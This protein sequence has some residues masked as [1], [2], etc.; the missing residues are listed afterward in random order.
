MDTKKIEK[1]LKTFG[2]PILMVISG[3]ILLVNPDGATALVTKLVGWVLVI[4]GA[5]KLVVPAVDKR[6]I[7]PGDWMINGIMILIGVILLAKPLILA[8]LIGRLLGVVLLAEGIRNL[9]ISGFG[10]V[11]ALTIVAGAVLIIMPRTLTNTV[12]AICGIVLMVIGVV[13]ILGKLNDMKRLEE[14]S[15]PNIIDAEQ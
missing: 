10:L 7:L 11:T 14:G 1:F 4:C 6:P 8:N 5:A 12:L 15:D 3:L 2:L 9:R 13:N